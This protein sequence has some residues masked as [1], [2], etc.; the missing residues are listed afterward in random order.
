[1][2][3]TFV[4]LLTGHLVADFLFQPQWM[5]DRKATWWVTGVHGVIVTVL[6]AALLGL[7]WSW[8]LL[9][10]FI[11][12]VAIDLT[13]TMVNRDDFWVFCSD[14]FLHLMVIGIIVSIYP[15]LASKGLWHR[16]LTPE[17]WQ[18][19]LK[20]L[21]VLSGI[22][23]CVPVGGVIISKITNKLLSDE[24][25]RN[26][27]GLQNGGKYIGWLERAL[28]LILMYLNIPAGIGFLFAAKSVLRFG[29]IKDP[30]H[31]VVTE[32]IIIGSFTSFGWALLLALAITKAMNYW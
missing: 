30:E 32:Y 13:K 18:F 15:D 12:H 3:E 16:T 22:I 21:T 9:I 24:E 19:G 17:N 20:C 11:T 14:Q 8:A 1:M 4:V 5:V 26:F 2:I 6:S 29:E 28:V 10:L 25:R 23:V 27:V 31:R 7:V